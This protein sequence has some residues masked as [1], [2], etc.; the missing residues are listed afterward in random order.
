MNFLLSEMR[1]TGCL[2]PVLEEKSIAAEVKTGE[3]SVQ[4]MMRKVNK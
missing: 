1:R 4:K 2:A 3:K